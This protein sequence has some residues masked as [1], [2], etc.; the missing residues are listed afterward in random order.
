MEKQELPFELGYRMPAEWAEHECTWMAWPK[1]P[2]TFPPELLPGAEKAYI[3]IIRNLH[4]G[5]RVN[6][7]VDSD[8]YAARITGLLQA[9]GIGMENVA[10][11]VI[12]TGDVWFRDYGPIF[13]TKEGGE[14]AY[15]HWR[16]NA[17][18]NKYYE[19]L[20]DTHI[21][22]KIPI[23]SMRGFDVPMVLEGGSIDTNGKGTFLTTEQCLLNRNRNPQMSREVIEKNLHDYLGATNII[24]LKGGIAGDDT[25]G[26][27][28][29]IARFVNDDT[30]VCALEED[31]EDENFAILRQNYELLRMARDQDGNRLNVV[32]L[33]MPEAVAYNGQRLPAS[34][35]NFYIANRK[36]LVPTFG[37]SN[38]LRAL[39]ILRELFPGRAV[40]G[41]GCRELVY[42]FG[43]LHCITQQQPAALNT[44]SNM[45]D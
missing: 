39:E 44:S 10:L 35:A 13:L 42:G 41:I 37:G 28:D 9:D 12:G 17:W 32:P 5:E 2:S 40:V 25:D 34:Y 14:V 1:D 33:P 20:N 4:S 22:E 24:W 26:H 15:T 11:H 6:L 8:G 18:G 43:A 45:P 16:F 27:V 30:V 19:L 38:D 29:D 21:P 23:G 36:V 7:L 31:Q 3:E